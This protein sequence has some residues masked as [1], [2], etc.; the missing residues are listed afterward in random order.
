MNSSNDTVKVSIR[1]AMTPGPTIGRV[2]RQNVH[3]AFSPKS[4]DA[5]SIDASNP[6]NRGISTAIAKGRQ[7]I[8][9]PTVTV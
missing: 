6:S 5:S 2:T 9:C 1:L 3:H 7:M 4:A 8:M